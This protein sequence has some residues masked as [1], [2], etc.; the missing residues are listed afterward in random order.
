[1]TTATPSFRWEHFQSP[2]YKPCERRRLV[3]HVTSLPQTDGLRPAVSLFKADPYLT[4]IAV[5]ED[6]PDLIG[7]K[8]LENGTYWF[9][10]DYREEYKV[11]PLK[12]R[13]QMRTARDFSVRAP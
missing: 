10:L 8:T 3:M 13:R 11:G 12:M 5:G 6:D 4:S 2:E 9:T 7:A 1:M